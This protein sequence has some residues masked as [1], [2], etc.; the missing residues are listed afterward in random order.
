MI[1]WHVWD[2]LVLAMRCGILTTTGRNLVSSMAAQC[3][4]QL[5]PNHHC[6]KEKLGSKL[7]LTLY[8][9]VRI[10]PVYKEKPNTGGSSYTVS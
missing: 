3:L 2:G 1:H 4:T 10:F 5:L 9:D 7:N 8:C 6:A